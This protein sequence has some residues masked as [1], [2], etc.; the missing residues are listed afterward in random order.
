MMLVCNKHL[1]WK[2]IIS[3]FKKTDLKNKFINFNIKKINF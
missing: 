2:E 3:E 1:E